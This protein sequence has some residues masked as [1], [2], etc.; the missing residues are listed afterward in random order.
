MDMEPFMALYTYTKT[1][2]K[3]RRGLVSEFVT[4]NTEAYR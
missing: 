4:L 2:L 1:A 3:Y